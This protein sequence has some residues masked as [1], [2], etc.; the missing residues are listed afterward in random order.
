MPVVHLLAAGIGSQLENVSALDP[1]SPSTE[2]IRFLFL[3]LCAVSAFIL[4][5]VWGVLFYSLIRFRRKRAA[6]AQPTAEPPQVY[7]SMPIEIAWTVAPGIIVFLLSLVIVRTEYEVRINYHRVPKDVQ[8]L[9]VT[10]IGHQWWWEYVVEDSGIR[11]QESG[12]KEAVGNEPRTTGHGQSVIT[13]NELHIPVSADSRPR[14]TFLTLLSNDVCHSFWVPR[15]AGKTDLI[16]GRRNQT[17]FETTEPGLYLGQC[18]EYCG[19]QH[20]NM[21]LRVYVDTPEDFSAW[22]ANEQK[23]AVDDPAVRAGQQALLAQSCINCH[24]VRGTV[25]HG[26]VGPDLTH[27][28][29]RKTLGAGMIALDR[30]N[31]RKWIA[32]PQDIKPGALMPAFGNLGGHNLEL[33]TDYLMT[34][35]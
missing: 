28:A 32:N 27:L 12:E 22:L 4:A 14:K 17:W 2:S 19:T 10:V 20:A 34:L 16:P 21:L 1:A 15:L 7:G 35:K 11:G 6:S 33:I 29:A 13:A 31:L 3:F 5:I 23:P 24:T 25:A 18:A 30:E 8:A 9:E 26:R